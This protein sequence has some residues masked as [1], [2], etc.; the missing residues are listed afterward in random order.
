MANEINTV[1]LSVSS[2]NQVKADNYRLNMLLDSILN[3]AMISEDHEHLVFNTRKVE[4]A[5]KFCFPERY[6][7]KLV[8][9]KTQHTRYGTNV[10][11][12]EDTDATNVDN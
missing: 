4:D 5:L 8:T 7:K 1:T 9:L 2:Y 6:K 12:K 3:E 11:P 10:A